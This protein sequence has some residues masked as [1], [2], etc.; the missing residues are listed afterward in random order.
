[1]KHI[2]EIR[3]YNTFNELYKDFINTFNTED[4]D[5][6]KSIIYKEIESKGLIEDNS[7]LFIHDEF[8]LLK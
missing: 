4:T 3:T 6:N 1:M 2:K 5:T 7:I 8:N